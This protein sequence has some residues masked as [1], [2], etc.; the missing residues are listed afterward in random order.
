MKPLLPALSLVRG[1]DD[2][3][4]PRMYSNRSRSQR[5]AAH[6]DLSQ[7]PSIVLITVVGV[8]TPSLTYH[9]RKTHT[10]P[11]RL[12]VAAAAARALPPLQRA[13]S[14]RIMHGGSVKSARCDWARLKREQGVEVPMAG[15]DWCDAGVVEEPQRLTEARTGRCA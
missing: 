15:A 14:A 3:A 6:G 10:P 11:A 2:G 7:F 9:E 5:Q 4:R 12:Y 8:F 13:C 1:D